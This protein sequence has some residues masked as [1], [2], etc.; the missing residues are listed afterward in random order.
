MTAPT[1]TPPSP[2][3]PAVKDTPARSSRYLLGH[4]QTVAWA[5]LVTG[6]ALFCGFCLA[7]T[8]GTYWF[9]FDSQIGMSVKL[10]VSRGRVDLVFPDGT[11]RLAGQE[12]YI[13][14]F[15]VTLRTDDISQAYLT[16]EDTYSRQQLAKVFLLQRSAVTLADAARPR[17]E[18]SNNAYH[19]I[20]RD[21]AG[22]IRLRL[23]NDLP[24]AFRAQAFAPYGHTDISTPGIYD[25]EA[26]TNSL[27][28]I[29]R[30]GSA[31]LH[32]ISGEMRTVESGEQA[33]LILDQ[34]VIDVLPL[35]TV[36]LISSGFGDE[37]VETRPALPV[38]WACTNLPPSIRSEPEGEWQRTIYEDRVVLR[39]TRLGLG[40]NH[41]ETRCSYE[42]G[43]PTPID[44][45][46]Y[47]SLEIRL[48]MKITEQD[49]PLCGF[50]GSECPVM[51]QLD[52]EISRPGEIVA[53][54]EAPYVHQV[55]RH[56]FYINANPRDWVT[57]CDTCTQEHEKIN[58]N[59]WYVYRSGNLLTY[60]NAR[61]PERL[62][63]LTVY[64][65]GHA[66]EAVLS[67]LVVL[68]TKKQVP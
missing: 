19:V 47:S 20:L 6:F 64:A 22:Q 7:S 46:Q 37:D 48:E 58:P 39:M 45:T 3:A 18:W 4:P 51:I 55:W 21:V 67:D 10:T 2:T 34:Q 26:R 59:A 54:G 32:A 31:M 12:E 35:D 17:F 62:V 43:F 25:I 13:T 9:L 28:V 41:A 1:N 42:F 40:L 44:I 61:R 66:Y 8:L 50:E 57:L 56:G 60:I 33:V 11:S 23:Q 14:D 16:F 52:Y 63:G 30:S 36:S 27:Q 68:A 24:R 49:V 53:A 65:S 5:V 15:N 38:G 29:P